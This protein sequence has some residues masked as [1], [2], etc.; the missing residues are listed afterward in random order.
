MPANTDRQRPTATDSDRQ[1][2]TAMANVRQ[3][4][5]FQVEVRGKFLWDLVKEAKRVTTQRYKYS[6]NSAQAFRALH[7]F[8]FKSFKDD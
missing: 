5:H 6:S 4:L 2:P 8:V 1:Y 7:Y 3:C